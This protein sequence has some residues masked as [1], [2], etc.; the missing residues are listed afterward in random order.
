MPVNG[1][2]SFIAPWR[3]NGYGSTLQFSQGKEPAQL[4]NGIKVPAVSKVVE[5]GNA[6]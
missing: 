1:A 6:L 4:S 2:A 3:W 5:M